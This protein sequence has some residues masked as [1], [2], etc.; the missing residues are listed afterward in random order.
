LLLRRITLL[1]DLR[2]NL[3]GTF[4]ITHLTVGASKIELGGRAVEVVEEI[5]L[6]SFQLSYR[7]VRGNS[8]SRLRWRGQ[9]HL[10]RQGLCIQSVDIIRL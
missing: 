5:E 6:G 7:I 4:R 1:Q 3:S 8:A 10:P 2:Q 9:V